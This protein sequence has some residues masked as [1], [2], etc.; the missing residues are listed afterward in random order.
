MKSASTTF[1]FFE[2]GWQ[3]D[4]HTV[5]QNKLSSICTALPSEI[6]QQHMY[7]TAFTDS[8][9]WLGDTKGLWPTKTSAS[10]PLENGVT[11]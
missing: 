10:K 1:G 6:W 11:T 7:C 8:Q 3:T 5:T 2:C 4:R 9:H